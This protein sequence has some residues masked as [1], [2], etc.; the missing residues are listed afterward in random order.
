M[1]APRHPRLRRFLRFAAVFFLILLCG[2]F[3]HSCAVQHALRNEIAEGERDPITGVLHGLE[4]VILGPAVENPDIPRAACLLVHGFLGS[5]Q[6]FGDLGEQL[7]DLGFTVRKMRLPGHGTS[8][9]DF[10][11][12]PPGALYKAVRQEYANLRA[13]FDKVYVVG[14]SMGGSL[15]TLLASREDVDRLVLLSPYYGVTYKWY[16]GLSPETWNGLVGWTV[17]YVKRPEF[18]I[19]INDRSM[20]GKYFMYRIL[21]TSGTRRLIALGREAALDETLK[22]VTCPV[23]LV[24]SE[25]DDASSPEASRVAFEKMGSE[26]KKKLWLTRSNHVL[27]WDYDR[28]EVKAGVVAF[29][30]EEF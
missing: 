8:A 4:A 24:Q 13:E 23:L 2:L 10:N 20:L 29:L 25:G 21:P 12:Q 30:A 17:P 7:A 15:S 19:K 11:F 22:Q 6:D 3:C 27:M 9:A 18:F 1:L 26:V 14:F 16:Y 5:V 28:E